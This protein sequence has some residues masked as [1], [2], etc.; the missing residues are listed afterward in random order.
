LEVSFVVKEH[1]EDKTEMDD[2]A[3]EASSVVGGYADSIVANA[4]RQATEIRREA[5]REAELAR[6]EALDSANRVLRCIDALERPLGELVVTL[7]GEVER[8]SRELDSPSEPDAEPD[9]VAL[10]GTPTGTDTQEPD[11]PPEPPPT[12]PPTPYETVP[13]YAYDAPERQDADDSSHEHRSDPEAPPGAPMDGPSAGSP[14]TEKGGRRL[15]GRLRGAGGDKGIF[16]SELGHCAVCQKP[17]MAGSKENLRLSGW[18][19][20]G[21]VGVCPDC[22]GEGWQLPDGARRPFR[23]AGT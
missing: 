21:E 3:R 18:R 19:V 8:L 17:F 22:Q 11:T 14:G 12:V 6:R 5:G 2:A 16:V 10:T 15:F 9:A 4:E 23:R 7:R 20:A 1:E 13:P